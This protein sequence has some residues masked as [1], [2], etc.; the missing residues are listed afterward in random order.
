[1][2]QQDHLTDS[3]GSTS[4]YHTAMTPSWLSWL[5]ET[6]ITFP[7]PSVVRKS[8]TCWAIVSQE[9]KF[10]LNS[11]KRAWIGM[12]SS[13]VVV[14]HSNRL[15]RLRPDAASRSVER[16]D[17]RAANGVAPVLS[18]TMKTPQFFSAARIATT[19]SDY[20]GLNTTN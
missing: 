19:E 7:G 12:V 13:M 8:A 18:A 2:V 16:D 10:D 3:A 6:P 15:R 9:S 5:W 4:Q 17:H 11:L 14:A 20:G 1:M